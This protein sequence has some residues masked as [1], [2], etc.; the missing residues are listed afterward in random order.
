MLSHIG[1]FPRT[2]QIDLAVVLCGLACDR[3]CLYPPTRGR[4]KKTRRAILNM[5]RSLL[6]TWA[7]ENQDLEWPVVVGILCILPVAFGLTS[8]VEDYSWWTALGINVWVLVLAWVYVLASIFHF[9]AKDRLYE[10][11][12]VPRVKWEALARAEF[13]MAGIIFV[14]SIAMAVTITEKNCTLPHQTVTLPGGPCIC[15]K[16]NKGILTPVGCSRSDP[17]RF[18]P[19][20]TGMDG[21]KLGTSCGLSFL[22]SLAF[23]TKALFSYSQSIKGD[24]NGGEFYAGLPDTS[25]KP[26][27]L[28][29]DDISEG[30]SAGEGYHD[31]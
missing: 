9:F 15:L 17:A 30:A 28:A 31:L 23:F 21:G 12:L 8:S 26:Y 6:K 2:H 22:G 18:P 3:Q 24:G 16:V 20:S 14:S 1:P 29:Y 10:A 19:L 13:A 11:H 5:L 25:E 27:N 7:G 4:L